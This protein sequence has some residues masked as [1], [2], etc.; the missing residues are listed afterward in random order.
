MDSVIGW[1]SAL[2]LLMTLLVQ[3][4]AQ[5]KS[6]SDSGVSPWL[7]VGQLLASGGFIAYSALR[8]DTVF[9]V[10]NSLTALVA[11]AGQ[12]LYFHNQRVNHRRALRRGAQK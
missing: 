5:W 9:V 8:H 11:I 3:I 12:T 4:S 2:V 7:F 10:T 6:K 1:C